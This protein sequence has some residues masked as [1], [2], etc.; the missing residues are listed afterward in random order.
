MRKLR[1]CH[2]RAWL[3]R[4]AAF[5]LGVLGDAALEIIGNACVERSREATHYV[6]VVSPALTH[7]SCLIETAKTGIPRARQPVC[8]E[9]IGNICSQT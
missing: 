6:H 5:L 3:P 7:P 9:D 1:I 8:A 2:S 4:E